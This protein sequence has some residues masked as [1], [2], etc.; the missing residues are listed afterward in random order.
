MNEWADRVDETGASAQGALNKSETLERSLRSELKRYAQRRQEKKAGP[1]MY[2]PWNVLRGAATNKDWDSFYI[3]LEKA[4][5]N[6]Y[7]RDLGPFLDQGGT[8]REDYMFQM[9]PGGGTQKFLFEEVFQ[10]QDY[11][12]VSQLLQKFVAASLWNTNTKR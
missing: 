9:M 7:I 8:K 12:V 10:H 4:A 11:D 6:E 5:W 3:Y 2:Q 1:S